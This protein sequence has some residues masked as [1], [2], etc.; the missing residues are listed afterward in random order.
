MTTDYVHGYAAGE[1]GRLADQAA[2][3]TGRL[4]AGTRY[5]ARSRVLCHTFFKAEARR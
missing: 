4:H 3:L 5:P 1:T 2:S